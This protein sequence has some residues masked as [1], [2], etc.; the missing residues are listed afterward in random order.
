MHIQ[1][2]GGSLKQK[3]P[4]SVNPDLS[5]RPGLM[6]KTIYR[7]HRPEPDMPLGPYKIKL[8]YEIYNIKYMSSAGTIT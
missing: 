2:N 5:T 1:R 7:I 6:L 4:G 8:I 3:Q